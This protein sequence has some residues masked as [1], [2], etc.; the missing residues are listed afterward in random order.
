MERRWIY[1]AEPQLIL[2]ALP[3]R[4]T[5]QNWADQSASQLR[6]VPRSVLEPSRFPSPGGVRVDALPRIEDPLPAILRVGC[7]RSPPHQDLASNRAPSNCSALE[8]LLTRSICCNRERL[9]VTTREAR[10]PQGHHQEREEALSRDVGSEQEWQAGAA[11]RSPEQDLPGTSRVLIHHR[12]DDHGPSQSSGLRSR[13][14]VA[15]VT[16]PFRTGGSSGGDSTSRCR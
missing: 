11:T 13:G 12:G 3:H 5:L 9:P 8:R 4:Q 10:S 15:G 7:H 6:S 16:G 2:A 14:P 1:P